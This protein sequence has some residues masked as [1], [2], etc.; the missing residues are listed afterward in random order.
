VVD[1]GEGGE[2]IGLEITAPGVVTVDEV[3]EVLERFG[4]PTIGREELS[5]VAA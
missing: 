4:Q 1:F 3:N 2:V 5:P